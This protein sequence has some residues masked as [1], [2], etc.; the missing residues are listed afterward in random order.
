MGMRNHIAK[1]VKNRK[2]LILS[3][4][5]LLLVL[6][7]AWVYLPVQHS[8]KVDFNNAL[9]MNSN[10]QAVNGGLVCENTGDSEPDVSD[11]LQYRFDNIKTGKYMVR[12]NYHAATDTDK[13]VNAIVTTTSSYSNGYESNSNSIYLFTTLETAG[14][15]IWVESNLPR[16]DLNIG[17]TFC[18]DGKIRIESIEITEVYVYSVLRFIA[19]IMA[20]TVLN[21]LIWVFSGKDNDR[22]ISVAAVLFGTAVSSALLFGGGLPYGHDTA[23]HSARIASIIDGM[24]VGNF[25]IHIQSE[26]FSGYGY[27][28]PLFYGQLF[29]YFPA[30]LYMLGAPFYMCFNIY[31]MAV[32]F[33]TAVVGFY[34]FKKIFKDTKIAA[35]GS[36]IYTLSIYRITNIYVRGAVGEYTAMIFL[37]LI[38]YGVYTIYFDTDREK[39][40]IAALIPL[41]MGVTGLIQSHIITTQI[42]AVCLVMFG[43]L[44][45]KKTFTKNT[46]MA[47]VKAVIMIVLVNIAFLIPFLDSYGMELNVFY[48]NKLI[49]YSGARLF[50]IFGVFFTTGGSCLPGVKGDLPM[51]IGM[52]SL[53]CLIYYFYR[54]QSDK[55][56]NDHAG[57]RTFGNS[58]FILAI[59]TIAFSTVYFPW[60]IVRHALGFIGRQLTV[61]QFSWRYLGLASVCIAVLICCVIAMPDERNKKSVF[62]FA[63]LM[64]VLNLIGISQFY[65]DYANGTDM[66]KYYS[67]ADVDRNNIGLGEYLLAGSDTNICAD[68]DPSWE[69]DGVNV[70]GYTRNGSRMEMY[71]ENNSQSAELISMPLWAYDNYYAC[72]KSTGQKLATGKDGGNRFTVEVPQGYTGYVTVRYAEPWYWKVSYVISAIAVVSLVFVYIRQRKKQINVDKTL[73]KRIY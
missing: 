48:D 62:L 32:N 47:L 24:K 8:I 28:T 52:S 31:I 15:E 9:G 17:I 30:L 68:N 61:I 46:I 38:L 25:N 35:V 54:M 50:Q 71:C 23:F 13:I 67:A 39:L 73:E 42:V 63:G 36:V 14:M 57:I 29:L 37:P 59:V 6:V 49:Q 33:A 41:V 43:L 10:M 2:L 18:H 12:V 51:C 5:E 27:A 1:I 11:E 64:V 3:I 16:E 20:L 19:V 26:A 7:A 66:Y 22:K 4:I 60:D 69:S 45:Y 56:G 70:S 44:N 72:D 55:G 58:M 53:L 34:S 65:R 21:V 40:S